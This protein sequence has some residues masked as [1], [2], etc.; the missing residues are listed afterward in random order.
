[1]VCSGILDGSHNCREDSLEGKVSCRQFYLDGSI[2]CRQSPIDGSLCIGNVRVVCSGVLDG[3]PN[4]RKDSLDGKVS[5]RQFYLDGSILCRQSP[6]DGSLCRRQPVVSFYG[7]D[8]LD[9]S[10]PTEPVTREA[11]PYLL[12]GFDPFAGGGL[13]SGLLLG[14]VMAERSDVGGGGEGKECRDVIATVRS[15]A[16]RSRQARFD[17]FPPR[18]RCVERREPRTGFVLR[19]L[20]KSFNEFGVIRMRDSGTG[21]APA[22]AVALRATTRSRHHELSRSEGGLSCRRDNSRMELR[23]ESLKVSG[24][25]LRGV[26]PAGCGGLVGLHSSCTC[27]V[28]R[29]LDL[30][31]VAARLRGS[32]PTEPVMREAHP[33]L[34]PGEGD[35]EISR[36]SSSGGSAPPAL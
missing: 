12:P 18:G 25:G 13:E 31:S 8:S 17:E 16:M 20:R 1:V 35:P 23:P 6:I 7:Y 10:F 4:C 27:L 28:E 11:H 22:I 36:P 29:Q 9:G 33:Y 34:L 14:V 3:S 26:W 30:S 24:M 2:L 5:C 32:F 15:V 21:F 19:I